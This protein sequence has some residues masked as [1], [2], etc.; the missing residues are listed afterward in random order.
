M[1]MTIQSCKRM[2]TYC[3]SRVPWVTNGQARQKNKILQLCCTRNSNCYITTP[4][5]TAHAVLSHSDLPVPH[6][7]EILIIQYAANR[8]RSSA[9]IH[10][11]R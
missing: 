6:L 8:K 4:A 10:Y 11:W 5:Q 2:S 7:E 3:A 9:Y 1:T